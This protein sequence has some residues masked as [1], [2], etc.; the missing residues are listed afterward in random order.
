M[1]LLMFLNHYVYVKKN[2]TNRKFS[3]TS[4]HPQTKNPH[5]VFYIVTSVFSR[6]QINFMC[7]MNG[8]L[9][10]EN[11]QI[12]W[13]DIPIYLINLKGKVKILYNWR[14]LSQ[15]TKRTR[16][17]WIILIP[18]VNSVK[19][20]FFFKVIAQRTEPNMTRITMVSWIVFQVYW[21]LM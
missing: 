20:F 7:L 3:L 10:F 16:K 1:L 6:W 5:K 14:P 13:K 17:P 19:H 11:M 18:F 12:K 8:L 21:I 15:I 4:K 2:E 9:Q